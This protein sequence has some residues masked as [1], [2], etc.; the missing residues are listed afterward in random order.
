MY[1]FGHTKKKT[2]RTLSN[3]LSSNRFNAHLT[4]MKKHIHSHYKANIMAVN[5]CAA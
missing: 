5:E 2:E 1:L 3:Y 4:Q